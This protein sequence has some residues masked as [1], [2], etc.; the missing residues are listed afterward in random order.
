MDPVQAG[1]AL[2]DGVADLVEMTRAQIADPSLVAYCRAGQPD[3]VRPCLLCNQACQV[4]DSR[5]PVVSCVLE[6][7]SGYETTDP[8]PAGPDDT[9]QAGTEAGGGTAPAGAA[10]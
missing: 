4:R 7:R 2:R 6:P 8:D 1:E 9:A 10:G 5:N 3:Q